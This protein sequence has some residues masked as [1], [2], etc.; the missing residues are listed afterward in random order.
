MLFLLLVMHIAH[1]FYV[2]TNNYILRLL[3]CH[4]EV[5]H[6]QR[7]NHY[8]FVRYD[9]IGS[10]QRALSSL[11]GFVMKKRRKRHVNNN[12]IRSSSYYTLVVLPRDCVMK[13]FVGGIPIS[14]DQDQLDMAV[15]GKFEVSILCII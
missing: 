8:A 6:F 15:I 4:G 5:V 1:I 7:S 12:S 9:T 13:L 14:M 3:R 10:A 2:A 11:N